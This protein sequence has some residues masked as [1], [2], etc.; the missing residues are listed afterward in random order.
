[1]VVIRQDRRIK[2]ETMFKYEKI[3][4]DIKDIEEV[5]LVVFIDEKYKDEIKTQKKIDVVTDKLRQQD[6]FFGFNF[7][8][9]INN[10]VLIYPDFSGESES[11]YFIQ[12]K[13]DMELLLNCIEILEKLFYKVEIAV[14]SNDMGNNI[15]YNCI[16][17]PYEKFV[18][19]YQIV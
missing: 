3:S 6:L 16:Y 19:C 17:L 8:S 7:D 12:N 10:E 2:E 13:N 18:E 4:M 9:P 11:G 15:P 1:M 5:Y 14:Y